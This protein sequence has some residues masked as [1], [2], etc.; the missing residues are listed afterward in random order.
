MG[1]CFH[2]TTW[3]S[4][5]QVEM[6]LKSLP[7]LEVLCLRGCEYVPDDAVLSLGERNPRVHIHR[8]TL[9]HSS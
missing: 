1:F 7:A 9:E 8:G 4:C 5:L 3:R 6:L 2:K